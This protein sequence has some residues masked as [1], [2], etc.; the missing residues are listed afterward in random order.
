MPECEREHFKAFIFF[1]EV[2][3]TLCGTNSFK[4]SHPEDLQL[5]IN[6]WKGVL[7]IQSYFQLSEQV[8]FTLDKNHVYWQ[9][10]AECGWEN[11]PSIV[12]LS[13]LSSQIGSLL[14]QDLW[15][16]PVSRWKNGTGSWTKKGKLYKPFQPLE[17]VQL[18]CGSIFTIEYWQER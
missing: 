12:F 1:K 15:S 8:D 17:N 11:Q 9:I 3:N 2:F 18:R 10:E 4:I 6:F 7:Q 13:T 5:L 16:V 14:E